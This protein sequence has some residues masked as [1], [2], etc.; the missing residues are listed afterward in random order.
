MTMP[1][2]E[3]VDE[4]LRVA[5]GAIEKVLAAEVLA[6]REELT[7]N[8]VV[9]SRLLEANA[10]LREELAAQTELVTLH[11]LDAAK[12]RQ[13][14]NSV[15]DQLVAAQDKDY[16]ALVRDFITMPL[17]DDEPRYSTEAVDALL[18]AMEHGELWKDDPEVE[19][20]RASREP[21]L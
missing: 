8:D 10:K 9:V 20:V 21:K 16:E 18:E 3:Q 5:A 2:K 19:A 15:K 7:A 4:A 11:K 1:T 14:L 13:E 12:L 6:L 17:V